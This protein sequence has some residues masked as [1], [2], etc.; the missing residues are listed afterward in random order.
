MRPGLL[1][2]LSR[3]IGCYA[4]AVACRALSGSPRDSEPLLRVVRV[5]DE[6]FIHYV[7]VTH[8]EEEVMGA[9]G[10]E[11]LAES[12]PVGAITY[13]D[14]DGELGRR[15]EDANGR[16]FTLGGRIY[17]LARSEEEAGKLQVKLSQ[18]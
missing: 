1:V 5:E 4:C 16:A 8:G 7:P 10:A 14:L 18:D 15:I 17:Y 13:G 12:C 6:S 9:C 3:C 2:D 11:R